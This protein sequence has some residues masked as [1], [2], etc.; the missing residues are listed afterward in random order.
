M[1]GKSCLQKGCLFSLV[2]PAILALLFFWISRSSHDLPDRF[3]LVVPVGGSLE[4]RSAESV[5]LPFLMQGEDL[6][7][8]DLLFICNQA[9][10]DTRIKTVLLEIGNVHS[11]PAKITEL[12]QAIARLRAGGRRV[13][14]WLHSAE[15]SDYML[16]AA[17][18]S[19]VVERGGYLL[20]DGLRAE[21]L[22]YTTPLGRV[23][24]AFQAAQWKKYKS[25]IEPYT[26]TGASPEY[27]EQISTLLEQVY[28]DYTGYVAKRRAIS[29]DSFVS[30]IDNIALIKAADAVKL[31]LADGVASN[32]E[33]KRS[34]ARKITG[35]PPEESRDL[36][37]AAGAYRETLDWPVKAS[38][39]DAVAV[40]TIS[41]PIVQGA[42]E[43]AMSG[44]EGTDVGTLRRSLDAALQDDGVK[45]LV[46]R[47]D[48]PG[49][50]A[51]ASS[52]ML[53]MLDSAAVKKPLVVSM[54]GVAASGGY[55]AALAGKTVFAQP[56]TQT[57][58]IGVYALK[59]EISEL[60]AKIGLERSVATRGRF[61]DANTLFK[62]LEGEAYEKFVSAS[63]DIYLDFIGKVARSRKMTVAAVDSVA[64]GRVWTGR[65][66]LRKGLVDREGGLFDAIRAAR[67]LAKMDMTRQ[68]RILLY[69][70]RKNWLQLL[71][72]GNPEGIA[73]SLERAA[74]RRVVRE[75]TPLSPY[76]AMLR[77]HRMLLQSGEVEVLAA[78]PCEIIIR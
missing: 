42:G 44:D 67:S 15:D 52:D 28:A 18:D 74:M 1:K 65:D 56:L 76:G 26:R 19:V 47:I 10:T 34:L 27:L 36:F 23:G 69:P 72:E 75:V 6:S 46:L 55:M 71:M 48:S 9:A 64:G 58:S 37:V 5:S 17:C 24:V 66:A 49:G 2:I 31:G 20:L 60:A 7:F 73:G 29:R 12:R 62:P 77:M 78:M 54:S 50:D 8:Q 13:V 33:L 63:G 39:R 53:Q 43:A 57:G 41:G 51:L 21:T 61:A 45:A 16:A 32:W 3:V 38:Q 25:A 70:E 14:A 59:P 30:I 11:S 40:I 4:E 22:Y 68:P 35:K